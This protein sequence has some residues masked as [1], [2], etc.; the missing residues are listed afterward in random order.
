M[1]TVGDPKNHLHRVLERSYDADPLLA[2]IDWNGNTTFNRLQIPRF[3]SEWAEL[4]K[5]SSS[6]EEANIVNEVKEL[7]V[8]CGGEVHLYLKFIGD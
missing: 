4:A 3:L 2:E 7:A 8:R 6:P 1:A 5:Q